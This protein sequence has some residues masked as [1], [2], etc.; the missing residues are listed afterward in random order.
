VV[1]AIIGMM[2]VPLPSFLLDLLLT[3][4]ITIA[5]TRLIVSL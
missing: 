4:N 2:I 3:L 5:V 1:I